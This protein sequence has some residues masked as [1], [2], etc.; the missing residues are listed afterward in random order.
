MPHPTTQQPNNPIFIAQ[1]AAT[2]PSSAPIANTKPKAPDKAQWNDENQD[3]PPKLLS[4][5]FP[6]GEVT[7]TV[8]L[9]PTGA[10]LAAGTRNIIATLKL[11][12]KSAQSQRV[13]LCGLRFM[14]EKADL[15]PYFFV[16]PLTPLPSVLVSQGHATQQFRIDSFNDTP[17]AQYRIEPVVL[18]VAP[19]NDLL[20]DGGF[21]GAAPDDK[22][23]K[24]AKTA[25]DFDAKAKAS[26]VQSGAPCAELT[27]AI[28]DW[29]EFSKLP[30]SNDK[31]FNTQG[32]KLLEAVPSDGKVAAQAVRDLQAGER[33]IA[34]VDSW[35]GNRLRVE[36]FDEAGA[37]LGKAERNFSGFFFHDD[38]NNWHGRL[39]GFH[40]PSKVSSAKIT[41]LA[42]KKSWWDN[43]FFVAES[44][45]RRAVAV[46]TAF[47][48]ADSE[49]ARVGD[50][51]YLGED[52]ATQ[53]DWTGK[54][55][56]YAFIL[57]A[58]SAPR[59]MVGGEVKPLKC[60]FRDLS[61]TYNNETIRVRGDGELR[62]TGWTGNPRDVE[63]RHWIDLDA[64][65]TT[66]RRAPDNPQ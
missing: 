7:A 12:N 4:K 34:G 29:Q 17:A 56:N 6:Q 51:V 65:R 23:D 38:V 42:T 54:Y 53:G 48:I 27:N 25:W 44:N 66:E 1:R 22:V 63:P 55:G 61:K 2:P 30:A 5:E 13:L 8:E 59:D 39:L 58:M 19:E 43:A 64:M 9:Q 36:L 60:D 37:S 49:K 50:V 33:Y 52:R 32:E 57:S 31:R 15:S 40:A 3:L 14:V 47:T 24:T 21:E 16:L 62:Y 28:F 26:I 10:A 45:L 18:C 41:L 11:E 35:S 20:R 46:P